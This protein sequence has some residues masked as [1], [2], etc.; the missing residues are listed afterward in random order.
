[1]GDDTFG[2]DGSFSVSI[3]EYDGIEV[4]K[5]TSEEA[6][7]AA[8]RTMNQWRE[9]LDKGEG[10]AGVH[11]SYRESGAGDTQYRNTGGT[12]NDITVE[13]QTEGSLEYTVGGDSIPLA[14]AETGRVPTPNSPPP[15]D[16][17]ADWAREKGLEPD[18]DETFEEMVD[19]IRWAIAQRG[20]PGFQPG[21]L[22]AKQVGPTF[23]ENVT[24]RINEE[25]DE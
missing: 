20:I 21:R 25:I 12:A 6:F 10:A 16:P 19:G 13:P 15:F 14:V 8:V 5:I 22:A 11:G 2:D 17:I 18:G 4:E 9:N 7:K 23:E 3:S 1:M 24:E